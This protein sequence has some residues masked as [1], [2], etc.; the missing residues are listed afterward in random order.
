MEHFCTRKIGLS[1]AAEKNF[2][3]VG[4]NSTLAVTLCGRA[5]PTL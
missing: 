2:V 4:Q 1:G 5:I 3:E